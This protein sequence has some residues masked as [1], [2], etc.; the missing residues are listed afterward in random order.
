MGFVESI[1]QLKSS[2]IKGNS[3]CRKIYKSLDKIVKDLP[4]SVK[5]F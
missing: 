4:K 5:P 3:R 2:A 1:N